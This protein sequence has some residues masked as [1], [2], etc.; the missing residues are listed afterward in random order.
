[1]KKE[2]S[3]LI[4]NL[5]NSFH[6][7]ITQSLLSLVLSFMLNNSILVYTMLTGLYLTFLGAS[8]L[9]IDSNSV[10]SVANIHKILKINTILSWIL[11]ILIPF[12]LFI[13]TK[14]DNIEYNFLFLLIG[15]VHTILL[16]ISSGIEL[17]LYSCLNKQKFTIQILVSDYFGNA[18]GMLLFNFFLY[19]FFGIYG[20]ITSSLFI[21]VSGF[22]YFIYSKVNNDDHQGQ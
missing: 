9:W 21:S 5:T 22:L 11:L 10:K 1:M 20:S 15:A 2:I 16:G 3:Y 6:L 4:L 17:P 13:H 19:P 18:L 8:S 7:I 14:I 12:Y